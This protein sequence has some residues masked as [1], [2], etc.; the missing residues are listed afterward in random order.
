MRPRWRVHLDSIQLMKNIIL[1]LPLVALFGCTAITVRPPD[2]SLHLTHVLIRNNPKVIVQGFVDVMRDA[3]DRHGIS[4]EVIPEDTRVQPG[5]FVVTYTA[6]RSWDLA[7]YLSHAEIRIEESGRQVAY[8]EYHLRGKGGYS[9]MKWQGVKAKMDPVMEQLLAGVSSRQRAS[10]AL[11]ST[12]TSVTS[13]A[14]QEP[15]QP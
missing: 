15:R 9:M 4:S 3:F 5:Q 10:T 13:P 7:P 1:I 2:S 12:T 6:L 14:A 11:G 8:A